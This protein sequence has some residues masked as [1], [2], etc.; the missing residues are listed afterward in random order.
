MSEEQVEEIVQFY[1]NNTRF[2]LERLIPIVVECLEDA[3]ERNT[4]YLRA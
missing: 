1:R 3:L 4:A 2:R